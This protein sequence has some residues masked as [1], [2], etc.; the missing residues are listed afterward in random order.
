MYPKI[1]RSLN[2]DPK[3]GDQLEKA[4]KI[5]DDIEWDFSKLTAEN[6]KFFKQIGFDYENDEEGQYYDVLG[7][8]DSWYNGDGPDSISA[9]SYLKSK[10]STINYLPQNANDLSF[11]TAWS[12]GVKGYGV[13]EYL[14]YY[15]KPLAPRIT[16]VIVANGY[17]KSEKAFRENS[18]VKKLKMYV[19]DKPVA[20]LNLKDCRC[21]Q[22]FEFEPIGRWKEYRNLDWK[23]VEK[24]P[25]WTMKFEILEVYP[26]DKY[27]DTVISEI[28]FDGLDVLCLGEGTKILM[29][30]HSLKNIES[31]QEGDLVKSYDFKSKKLTDSKVSKPVSAVHSNLLKLKFADNEIVTTADHPFWIDKNGWAAVDAEKANKNYSQTTKVVNLKVGDKIFIPEKNTYSQIVDIENI[32]ARQITYTIE[33]SESDNFIANGMLVKTERV[34]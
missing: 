18:R 15:F 22:M 16:T 9:S 21:E 7:P 20:I 24:L 2:F 26:G 27:D 23:E 12:E 13:G 19:R 10:D 25:D 5:L 28:Y 34:K 4:Y 6:K 30:D 33:L 14:V 32:N 1:G 8:G 3:I 17:V 29:A 11:K 31:I